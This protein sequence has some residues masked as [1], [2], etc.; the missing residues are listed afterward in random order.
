MTARN[1]IPAKTN[2]AAA[3]PA[4]ISA[5]VNPSSAAKDP[6]V[7]V[8]GTAALPTI[9]YICSALD[10]NV[11]WDKHLEASSDP[12]A[13]PCLSTRRGEIVG[14]SLTLADIIMFNSI[15]EAGLKKHAA[16][17]P[18]LSRWLKYVGGINVIRTGAGILKS[19]MGRMLQKKRVQERM[20]SGDMYAPLPDAV[21]GK[22]VTRFPPEPSGY[23]HIGHAKAAFLNAHYAKKYKGKLLI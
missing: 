9:S 18:H 6:I 3:V 13:Q 21:E 14:Y 10:G 17:L 20:R 19:L 1:T 11:W 8:V 22:V 12:R 23:L 15:S 4:K 2:T 5:A 16:P 7:L